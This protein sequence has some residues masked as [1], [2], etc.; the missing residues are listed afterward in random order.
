MNKIYLSTALALQ[1]AQGEELPKHFKGIAYSGGLTQPYRAVVDLASLTLAENMPL[2]FNHDHTQLI[3]AITSADLTAQNL[4]VAG[5]IFSDLDPI[6]ESIVKKAQRNAAYQMSIGIYNFAREDIPEGQ[7][8]EVNQQTFAG[9]VE[10]LRRGQVRE[11]SI[12]ALGADDK[13]NAQFFSSS[14]TQNT[15]NPQENAMPIEELKAKVAELETALSAEQAAHQ[16][17]QTEKAELSANIE[18]ERQAKRTEEVKALFTAQGR[19]YCEEKAKP[20]LEMSAEH[21]AAI[22]ADLKTTQQPQG[23]QLP[24]HLFRA[25]TQQPNTQAQEGVLLSVVKARAAK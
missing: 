18:A 1:A 13:T 10:I 19:Q 20:Y 25:H 17:T 12:V 9:P 24:E 23:N 4:T 6:A 7:S 3:G 15:P 14:P 16:Q 8:I 11:V 21:F 5:D 2:L 22:A